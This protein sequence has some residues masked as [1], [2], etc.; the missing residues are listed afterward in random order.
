M[1]TAADTERFRLRNFIALL[2]QED[3]LETVSEPVDL[4]EIAPG[5]DGNAKAV[6]FG[7]VG[8]ERTQLVGN[9]MGSRRRLALAFG[10]T[11]GDS[12]RGSR[13]SASKHRLHRSKSRARKPRSMTS[14]SPAWRPTSPACRRICSTA[15]TAR[16]IFRPAS[17]SAGAT[18]AANAMSAIAG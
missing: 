4:I 14:C 17:T 5:L 1:T 7:C 3:E 12:P 2:A 9:V 13:K 11:E 18:T 10:A 15:R 16:P 6:L 8:P